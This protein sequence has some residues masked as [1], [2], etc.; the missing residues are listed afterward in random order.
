[1][2]AALSIADAIDKNKIASPNAWLL[3][4]KIQVVD[5]TGAVIRTLYYVKNNEEITFQGNL[6]LPIDFDIDFSKDVNA[7]PELKVTVFDPTGTIR[8]VMEDYGG[9][10]GF[11]VTL[12]VVN[13]ANLAAPSELEENFTVTGASAPG[14]SP[15]FTL[16][17]ENPLK[18]EFPYRRQLRDRCPWPYKGVRCGYAGDLPNC[19]YTLNGPNGCRQHGNVPRFG[20][21]PG[22]QTRTV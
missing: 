8:D 14:F 16:G 21:F 10:I 19:D 17:A 1:M 6:Y 13:S 20:G 12:T 5:G 2:P 18:Y 4:L 9:G 15:T 3:L 7:E 11:P 22:L